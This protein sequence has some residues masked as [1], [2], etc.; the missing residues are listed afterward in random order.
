MGLELD[1]ELQGEYST[2][3]GLLC[4]QAGEIPS[5]GDKLV[6]GGFQFTVKE[7]EDNRRIVTLL[8]TK[9]R[10]DFPDADKE[11]SGLVEEGGE[12]NAAERN[13]NP[14]TASG[15]MDSFMSLTSHDEGNRNVSSSSS[16][17]ILTFRDGEWVAPTSS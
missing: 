4:S 8:A 13:E 14:A 5:A 7:V 11:Y 17:D 3:G 1:E 6:F 10:K 12:T 15:F 9:L 2:V 16:G